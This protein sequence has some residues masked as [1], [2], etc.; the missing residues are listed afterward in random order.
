[1][2]I[3]QAAATFHDQQRIVRQIRSKQH[4]QS[5]V[6]VPGYL[7]Q[8]TPV[9]SIRPHLLPI[10]TQIAKVQIIQIRLTIEGNYD[11]TMQSQFCNTFKINVGKKT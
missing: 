9:L 3:R 4:P 2:Q 8:P 11:V 10:I 7:F 1:M 5:E 6:F